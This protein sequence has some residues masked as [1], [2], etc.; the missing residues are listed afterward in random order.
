[1]KRLL[2]F[3][4]R[5]AGDPQGNSAI[6]PPPPVGPDIAAPSTSSIPASSLSLPATGPSVATASHSPTTV[7]GAQLQT[8]QAVV[9]LSPSAGSSPTPSISASQDIDTWNR[10]YEIAE[11][12]EP[13]LMTDYAS[14]LASLQVN[15]TSKK[16]ISNSE[17]VEDVVKQLLED[18]E[19][20]QWR[21]P[22]LGNNVIIRKQTE[23]LAKF[24]LWS[25]PVVK[26]AVSTQ[27]YAAL[28][29]SSV[30]ILLP[31]SLTSSLTPSC[32]LIHISIA[33]D[34]CCHTG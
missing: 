4:R 18:R 22:L 7:S 28:A 23:K 16:D 13:E 30:S 27:P 14:H 9:S 24:L 6:T 1:M 12:R 15:P 31:V 11:D 29:W 32:M 33:T 5:K 26:S 21:L 2:R 25:D 34:K 20:K 17:F 19:K 10:A 8:G 3:K